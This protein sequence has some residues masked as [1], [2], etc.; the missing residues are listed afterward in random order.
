MFREALTSP[1]SSAGRAETCVEKIM[2]LPY[3]LLQEFELV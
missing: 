3:P 1:I 2:F